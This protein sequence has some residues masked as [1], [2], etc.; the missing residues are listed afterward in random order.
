MKRKF[1]IAVLLAVAPFFAGIGFI[2]L[3]RY[4]ARVNPIKSGNIRPAQYLSVYDRNGILLQEVRT[5]D[6]KFV[7]VDVK[8]VSRHFI[9]AVI[10]A[11]DKRFFKHSGI[12]WFAVGRAAYQNILSGKTR[13]GASTITL[14]F[15]KMQ[16]PGQR[17]FARKIGE[18]KTAYRLEAGM[19]KEEILSGY[20]SRLPF[21]N[22]LFGVEAASLNYFGKRANALS[23]A[24]S[25]FLAAI[26]NAPSEFNPY[27]NYE[28]I[29]KRQRLI[30]S[31]MEE[32]GYISAEDAKIAQRERISVNDIMPLNH[33]PHFV[34]ALL[35]RIPDERNKVVTTL[36]LNIQNMAAQ[37]VRDIVNELKDRQVTNAAAIVI[38]NRSGDI[39]A[40]VGSA[41][42]WDEASL[43][44]NDG[45]T[46]LRQP[47][48]ALK[49]FIYSL[50]I[51]SGMTTAT[52]LEDVEAHYST[53]I[54]DF[55]PKNYSRRFHGPVRLREALANSL[56]IPAV[57]VVENIGVD[58]VLAGLKEFGFL[59]LKKDA[60]YYGAGIVLGNG[61]VS[62][63]EL[64]RAYTALSRGG[65]AIPLKEILE[66]EGAPGYDDFKPGQ[67]SLPRYIYLI[68]D[69]LKDPYAR[70]MEFGLDSVIK[71]PFPCAV[72][73]GTSRNYRDNW[74]IGYTTDYTVGVWVGNF[75]GAAM[76]QIS[77]VE[78]AGPLFRRIMMKLYENKWPEEF[79][80]P[81]D[82]V[83]IEICPL[84]GKAKGYACPSG[85]KEIFLKQEMAMIDQ[86]P[87]NMH[88]ILMADA[89]TGEPVIEDGLYKS[90]NQGVNNLEERVFEDMPPVYEPWQREGKRPTA[91]HKLSL[92]R[93]G[94]EFSIISPAHD[95]AYKRLT[96][97]S[98]EYQTIR[99]EAV[100]APP[101]VP[102][103]WIVNGKTAG[104]T[105][106]QHVMD[107]PAKSGEFSLLAV[108]E[109][110]RE[111]SREVRFVVR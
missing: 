110:R 31:R 27:K 65:A 99:F 14:Q 12:D 44:Q 107:W 62:L 81:D 11:E 58:N 7:P 39:L 66:P 91:P 100:G 103:R 77:G 98:P 102:V 85:V 26:P 32:E 83:E 47:G 73:T 84:S 20:I 89:G 4:A 87:C 76:Q 45:V 95:A 29:K 56:N 24:Q 36:D 34:Q 22:Q 40:Y 70:A 49:P 23:L 5:R 6:G 48:S 82:L 63:Y 109:A 52:L 57:K 21:G 17:T 69:I 72:K 59:S 43:G 61:D 93:K 13:S 79:L 71:M 90:N 60:G 16:N 41:D 46:A 18:M 1:L 53:P 8:E 9:N 10:A 15:A 86:T 96:D 35:P 80:K 74:S 106:L 111:L 38:D 64:A 50:A 19:T 37:Q 105:T 75:D 101:N 104:V 55:S 25:T 92:F 88:R 42:F 68:T 78:G 3:F 94:D 97:L 108:P 28:G 33:A 54:G 30:L 67:V 2:E 51:E